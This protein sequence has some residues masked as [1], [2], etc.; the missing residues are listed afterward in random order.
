MVFIHKVWMNMVVKFDGIIDEYSRE[1]ARRSIRRDMNM[2]PFILGGHQII[3]AELD[4]HKF[5]ELI[6]RANIQSSQLKQTW[7]NLPAAVV[8][9]SSSSWALLI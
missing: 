1:R 6:L 4:G 9:S 7:E 3:F 8:G 2:K 5:Q